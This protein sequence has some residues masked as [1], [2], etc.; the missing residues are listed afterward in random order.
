MPKASELLREMARY[1]GYKE[2]ASKSTV[3]GVTY[4]KRKNLQPKS[5]FDAGPWC[6]MFVAQCALAAGGKA[7]LDVVGDFAYTVSHAEWF[8]DHGRWHKGTAGIRPGDIVFYDWA[9]NKTIAQIDHVATVEK[10]FSAND[11]QT[12]EGNTSDS[13]RRRRRTN[14]RIVGYGRP[15]YDGS[16]STPNTSVT[17]TLAELGDAPPFPGT[18]KI[19]QTGGTVRRLQEKLLRRLFSLGRSGVD[20]DFGPATQAA[21]KAFQSGNDLGATGVVDAK[22]W[23]AIWTAPIGR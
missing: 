3:F 4:R 8:K 1:V 18:V 6:D 21:V 19:G 12:I 14:A 15:A 5:A 7:M 11:I 16:A 10:V 2:P 17:F 9:G 20:G 23:Q 22:T 13:C